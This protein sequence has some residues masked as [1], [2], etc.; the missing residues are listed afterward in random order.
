MRIRISRKLAV[1]VG[2][3]AVTVLYGANATAG[4]INISL[5]Q[6]VNAQVVRIYQT[7]TT[8]SWWSINEITIGCQ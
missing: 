7:G 4:T 8:S 6:T 3:S 2:L 5:N 1:A